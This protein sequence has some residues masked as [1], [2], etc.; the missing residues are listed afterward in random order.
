MR[1]ALTLSCNPSA[2]PRSGLGAHMPPKTGLVAHAPQSAE[3]GDMGAYEGFAA[4]AVQSAAH[5]T[6]LDLGLGKLGGGIG[7]SDDAAAG[8]Q[9][10]G[11]PG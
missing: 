4:S 11:A 8:E 5:G 6:E 2:R 3:R 10:G 9:A 1:M 7:T